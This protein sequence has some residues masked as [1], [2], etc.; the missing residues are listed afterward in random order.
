MANRPWLSGRVNGYFKC[1]IEAI[2]NSNCGGWSA[3][4][5]FAAFGHMTTASAE[6]PVGAA[7]AKGRKQTTQRPPFLI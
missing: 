3:N 2:A 5:S 4:S 7:F 6:I 1:M